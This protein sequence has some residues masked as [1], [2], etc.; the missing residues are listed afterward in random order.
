MPTYLVSDKLTRE[1][2]MV[3]AQRPS[4]AIAALIAD[5]F[6]VSDALTSAQA[7]RHAYAGI[8]FIDPSEV[9]E[10]ISQEPKREPL[11]GSIDSDAHRVTM[12]EGF[13]IKLVEDGQ[14]PAFDPEFGD[15]AE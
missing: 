15:A 3:E 6:T 1:N 2:I 11:I 7:I 8:P 4:G 9:V 12:S 14:P 13:T 10:T 5:R